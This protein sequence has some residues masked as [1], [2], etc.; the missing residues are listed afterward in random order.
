MSEH[1]DDF[2][3]P[4]EFLQA[5]LAPPAR[6]A[7]DIIEVAAN[8]WAIHGVIAVDGEVLIAEFTRFEEARAILDGLA[9]VEPGTAD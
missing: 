7:G 5:L 3:R 2:E 1:Q 6:I 9:V 4:D 8:T